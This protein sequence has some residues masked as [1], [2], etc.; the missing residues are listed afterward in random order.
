MNVNDSGFMA[1]LL[2][3]RGY[4]PADDLLHADIVLVNTCSVRDSAERKA[5]TFIADL[6]HLKTS[7]P[8]AIVAVCG[9][10]A[11]RMGREL[12]KAYKFIDYVIG[13]NMEKELEG[14]VAYA[15]QMQEKVLVGDS[16]EFKDTLI[17]KRPE[18]VCA[19]V[20]I[21]EGCDNFCS[22]CIVPYVRGREKSR[23]QEDIIREIR[24]L[25]KNIFKEVMLL[26]QN[27]NSYSSGLAGLL[28][29][30][31][32]VDGIE[33]VRFMTSHPKDMTEEIIEAVA[34][35]P[36][37]C[38]Y[39][40]IPFQSGDDT[41]LKRM[42]RGYSRDYYIDLVKKIRKMVPGA[43]ITGDAIAGFPGETEGQFLNTLRLI[44]ECRLDA[45]NTLA[46]NP[47]PGTKAAEMEG[48]LTSDVKSGRLQRLMSTVE[49]TVFSVNQELVGTVQEVL[50][51]E[52]GSGRTR[53][54]KIVKF[55]A[56]LAGKGELLGLRIVSA[57]SW[58]LQGDIKS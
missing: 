35:T 29:E 57:K 49:K 40:H 4:T 28:K 30:V 14:L 54:N 16:G 37:V 15:G 24:G 25:D 31:S 50:V 19:F 13:P 18:N 48:Q 3:S 39:F 20:T 58:V 45:V 34:S 33:R 53:S 17:S 46:F 32:K 38:E 44:E 9:C 21:M 26:G 41:V 7:N 22:Y 1:G 27:V 42:N 5:K 43:A 10:M 56:S 36:K 8:D 55:P 51:E 6:T 47:R 52:N 2:E 11:E 12:T 23:P